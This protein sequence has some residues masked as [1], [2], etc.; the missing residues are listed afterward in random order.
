MKTIQI[1][2]LSL[3]IILPLPAQEAAQEPA[4]SGSEEVQKAEKDEAKKKSLT[5][6]SPDTFKPSE[7]I[8]EDLSV[9]FPVDI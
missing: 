7:K 5:Q 3:L 8:S 4:D 1:L 6:K 9:S 2:F